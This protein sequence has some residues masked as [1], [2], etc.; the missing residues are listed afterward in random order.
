MLKR[1]EF[2]KYLEFIISKEKARDEMDKIMR[3]YDNV[4]I[5]WIAPIDNAEEYIVELVNKAMSLDED[6]TI[7]HWL[8]EGRYFEN[9]YTVGDTELMYLPANHKYRKPDISNLDKLYDYLVWCSEYDMKIL[10]NEEDTRSA[11]IGDIVTFEGPDKQLR[12]GIVEVYDKN[13]T[14]GHPNIPSYDIFVLDEMRFYKHVPNA[15]VY[16]N[17][18]AKDINTRIAD[19]R[20][21]ERSEIEVVDYDATNML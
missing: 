4:F 16:K 11:D 10:W 1:K 19:I 6:E 5:D 9:E 18:A 20:E 14:A 3:K 13:G 2:R 12:N 17:I 7:S 21:T 15:C 8:W